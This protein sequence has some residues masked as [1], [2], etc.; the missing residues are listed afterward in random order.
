MGD[1]LVQIVYADA[2]LIGET[3]FPVLD[4]EIT[5]L[6]GW[7]LVKF[8]ETMVCPVCYFILN[9]ETEI[10]GLAY[11]EFPSFAGEELIFTLSLVD[12]FPCF[13]AGILCF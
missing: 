3:P 4:G 7:V 9:F 6:L 1:F 10:V 11:E 2:K 5:A 13:A 8:P 12:D